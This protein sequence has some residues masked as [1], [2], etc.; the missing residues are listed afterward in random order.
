M[1]A[2][3][4]RLATRR[5]LRGSAIA[6]S[7]VL[8]VALVVWLPS[9]PLAS[10]WARRAG[11]P[12]VAV[13]TPGVRSQVTTTVSA[14]SAR[15]SGSVR[16]R[17]TSGGTVEV[18]LSLALANAPLGT[19]HVRIDG[20]TVSGGGVRMTSSAVSIGTP[21]SP[22]LYQGAITSLDGT[23]I[24]ARVAAGDGR[25]LRLGLAL[26]VDAATGAASGTAQVTPA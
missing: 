19:V 9:G 11:T 15:V 14:F 3:R 24:A 5:G 13:T 12:A 8:P 22:A 16:Q 23:R 21:S 10:D 7:I 26:Q 17:S 25:A 20:N 1:G 6:A 4:H 18:D 2:C